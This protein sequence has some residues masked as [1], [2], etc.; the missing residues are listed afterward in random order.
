MNIESL[1]TSA[2]ETPCHVTDTDTDQYTTDNELYPIKTRVA[3]TIEGE[4]HQ[5]IDGRNGGE[6]FSSNPPT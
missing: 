1:Q 6:I 4:D 5:N 3:I 2:L